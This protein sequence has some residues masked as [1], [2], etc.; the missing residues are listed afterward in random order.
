MA[1]TTFTQLL[2]FGACLAL[3][4]LGKATRIS[5]TLG[6]SPLGFCEQ[7]LRGRLLCLKQGVLRAKCRD[8]NCYKPCH[9][10]LWHRDGDISTV[11]GGGGGGGGGGGAEG[12][13]AGTSVG[14]RAD[15][16]PPPP[17]PL[18]HSHRPGAP[19]YKYMHLS[20]PSL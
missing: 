11:F 9:A 20:A 19:V 2:S 15:R 17:P 14:T 1:T 4:Y 5:R 13:S 7:P 12:K 3:P 16:L 8:T 18:S 6:F 10:Q